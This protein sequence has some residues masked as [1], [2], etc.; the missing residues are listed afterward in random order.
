MHN[1]G[2]MRAVYLVETGRSETREVPVPEPGPHDVLIRVKY[3]GVCGSDVHFY[4]KGRIGDFVVREPL[5]LGHECSGEVAG[6]GEGVRRLAV[7][8][9]VAVEPGI[10]CRHCAYC[11]S[12][13]YNLCRDVVFLSAPPHDGFFQEYAVVP[14][15]FAY[16]LPANLPTIVGATVEPLAVGM[17]AV[18]LARLEPGDSVVVLG[19][20][21]I[22]LMAVC[23]ARAAGAGE[24]TAVD[25]VPMRLEAALEM[26]AAQVVNAAEENVTETLADSCDVL[27]DCVAI[28]QTLGQ[29]IDIVRPGGRIAWV[30]MAAEKAE[31]PFQKVQAKEVLITG[32]FRYANCFQ[33]AI[34]LLATGQIDTAPLVTHE[35]AFPEVEEAITFAAGNKNVALKTMVSFG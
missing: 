2:M 7:G 3:C 18:K 15:D 21:P 4:E 20:G 30:G 23:A 16:K 14:D 25:L 17:Q 1:T 6:V 26:G 29:G 22:G 32:V 10:P 34:N 11:L 9:R 8:D 19:A 5:V 35:F 24:V 31:I 33:P 13:R 12:G 27:L 28:E